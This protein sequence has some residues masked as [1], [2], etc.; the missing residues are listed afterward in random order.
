MIID[1]HRHMWSVGERHWAA[2]ADLPGRDQ[3]APAGFD[4]EETTREIVEEMDAAGVDRSVLL[5]ADFAARLGDAPFDIQEENRLT[6]EASR[7]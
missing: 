5:V 6:V 1:M 3:P 7:R 4:W 2:F